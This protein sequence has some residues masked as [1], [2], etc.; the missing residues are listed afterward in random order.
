MFCPFL[1]G[2]CRNDCAFK[3]RNTATTFGT[4]SCLIAVKLDCINEHQADQLTEITQSIA[5]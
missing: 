5:K 2:E 3:T 4:S 1:N